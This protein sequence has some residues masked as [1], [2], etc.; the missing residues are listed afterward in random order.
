MSTLEKGALALLTAVDDQQLLEDVVGVAVV[1]VDQ[2]RPHR[3]LCLNRLRR[4]LPLR[5]P[6]RE[7]AMGAGPA[8]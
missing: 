1:V 4:L 3:H 2:Q 8:C 6:H 5:P 7:A